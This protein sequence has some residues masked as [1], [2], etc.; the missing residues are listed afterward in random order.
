M[1]IKSR[2]IFKVKEVGQGVIY[3]PT[4]LT[5]NDLHLFNEG[6][7]F[8]L[9]ENLGAHV[10][11]H[12]GRE[13]T[14][15]AVWAPD[16]EQVSVVGDFNG[17]QKGS[18]PLKPRGQSGIWQGIIPGVS[19]G[20]IYKYHIVSRYRGYQVEKADPFAFRAETPPKTGSI[21]WDLDY[22]WEDQVWMENQNKHNTLDAP[23]AI[24]EVHLGSW[25]RVAE[26]G[27]RPLS[28][29]EIALQLAEYV[30]RMGFTHVEFLPLMEHPFYGSWGY[31]T[32]GYFAP[33]SLYGTPQDLMYLI[34]YLHQNEIG[35]ILDWV[36]SHFPTDEHGLGYFDGTHLY[37]HA[38]DQLH[39]QLWAQGSPEFSD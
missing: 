15:F 11:N 23:L 2:K 30:K 21:T 39:F 3:D 34:D 9:Y 5:D 20:A 12:N 7:H 8:R 29:R 4:L 19:K 37:E 33:T 22:P 13:G 17:W 32:T 27:N 10:V 35:V 28:Y 31:Q 24:Y 14:H 26:E 36:P 25:R 6:T 38:E 1:A 18:H 16:A